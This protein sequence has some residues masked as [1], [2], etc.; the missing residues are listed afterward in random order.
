MEDVFSLLFQTSYFNM[1]IKC[2][3]HHKHLPFNRILNTFIINIF[4][5]W[6]LLFLT[7]F[8]I[9]RISPWAFITITRLFEHFKTTR[10]KNKK[11]KAFNITVT[12]SVS[13]NLTFIIS[14][15]IFLLFR[16]LGTPFNIRLDLDNPL[17]PQIRPSRK[18][19][20]DQIEWLSWPL[21]LLNCLST[22]V[23]ICT[24][25]SNST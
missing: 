23:A 6:H 7:I 18:R 24:M 2:L 5:W 13:L 12:R 11:T 17:F 21:F 14:R 19:R 9:I 8:L 15:V 25:S 3:F 4:W 20:S 22:L 16:S 10:P 1:Y